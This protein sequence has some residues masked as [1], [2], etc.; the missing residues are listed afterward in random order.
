MLHRNTLPTLY[1]Q[2]PADQAAHAPRV[3]L[4]GSPL[5]TPRGQ[6]APA[7]APSRLVHL[8]VSGLIGRGLGVVGHRAGRV[9]RRLQRGEEGLNSEAVRVQVHLM[10][11]ARGLAAVERLGKSRRRLS[12]GKEK[13]SGR[14]GKHTA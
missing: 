6:A 1:G 3:A 5:P 13:N 4:V 2:P 8:V 10:D 7:G 9:G 12:G 14:K 11:Q